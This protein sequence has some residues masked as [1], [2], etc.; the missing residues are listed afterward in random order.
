M[1]EDK[2]EMETWRVSWISG[3][4]VDWLA[5]IDNENVVIGKC[6]KEGFTHKAWV[7]ADSKKGIV[8]EV[9]GKKNGGVGWDG[10]IKVIEV[11]RRE[12]SRGGGR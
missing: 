4:K 11:E 10:V 6:I 2:G 12:G 1:R 5:V 3:V 7:F 8:I 9:A